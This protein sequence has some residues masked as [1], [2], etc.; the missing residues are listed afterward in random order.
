MLCQ[1]EAFRGVVTVTTLLPTPLETLSCIWDAEFWRHL[2]SAAC[3]PLLAGCGTTTAATHVAAGR[4]PM[5]GGQSL[6][7][8]LFSHH[9]LQM[10]ELRP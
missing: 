10:K 1:E 4:H 3:C 6:G 7:V 5:G 9:I 2:P 8:F